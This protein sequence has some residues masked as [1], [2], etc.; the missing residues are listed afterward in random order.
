M[1]GRVRTRP[2]CKLRKRQSNF[3][4]LGRSLAGDRRGAFLSVAV[5]DELW[6]PLS[7]TVPEMARLM[8]LVVRG[9][10]I[11]HKYN[12]YPGADEMTFLFFVLVSLAIGSYAYQSGK[13]TGARA[14]YIAGRRYQRLPRS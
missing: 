9:N 7:G 12:S 13:R 4:L 8:T 1:P 3:Q 5:A 14:G 10:D 6:R 11:G 2:G